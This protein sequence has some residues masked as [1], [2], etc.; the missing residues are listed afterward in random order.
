MRIRP[1]PDEGRDRDNLAF[2]ITIVE[3][4][5]KVLIPLLVGASMLA[6]C[7]SSSEPPPPAKSTTVV[8]PQN[9]GTTVICQDGS[10]PPCG[11]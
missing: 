4:T 9:S 10:K 2:N 6:G 7:I 1:L 11:N 5:M 3:A 8:V